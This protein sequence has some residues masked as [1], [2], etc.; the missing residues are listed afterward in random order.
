MAQNAINL[1]YYAP[2]FRVELDGQPIAMDGIVSVEVDEN[3]ENP[4]MFSIELNE[5]LD[6]DTQRFRWLDSLV[7]T[8]GAEVRIFMGYTSRPA[9]N[10]EPIFWG[11]LQS[12]APAFQSSG[13]PALSVQGYDF[14]HG[15]QKRK[16]HFS[17]TDLRASEAAA[18]IARLNG[19]DAGGVE[20]TRTIYA[21]IRQSEEENDADLLRRLAGD[22][23]FEVFVRGKTLYFRP[24]DDGA[25]ELLTFEWRK[26]LVS[27]TPRLSTSAQV[28]EVVVRGWNPAA[29]QRI[30]G[31]AAVSDLKALAG[32]TSGAAQ[33]EAAEGSA[34]TLL[35]EDRP[36]HSQ[37]EADA[38]ARAELNRLN[39]GFITGSGEVVGTPELRMGMNLLI[40][41]VG[42]RLSGRYYV[43]SARHSLGDSGYRTTFEVRRNALGTS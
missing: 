22:I 33:V 15:M 43:K 23:G 8:P 2:R 30:E 1:D 28:S 14:S 37:E 27:F 20:A 13:V 29:K 10:P 35:I 21:S 39:D 24:P 19:L 36:I 40:K 18:E 4:A 32:G 9:P 17:G 25:T 26:N 41:G 11:K 34:V 12:L 6:P 38:L 7:L 5:T 3:L 16:S 31:R 42:T